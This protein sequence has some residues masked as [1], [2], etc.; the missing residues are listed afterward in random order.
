MDFIC[1]GLHWIACAT[2]AYKI[3][4]PNLVATMMA[5]TLVSIYAAG[6]GIGSLVGGQMV[7]K[8][9]F[10]LKKLF[11]VTSIIMLV[12]A[13]SLSVLYWLIG[14]KAEKKMIEEKKSVMTADRLIQKGDEDINEDMTFNDIVELRWQ[15]HQIEGVTSL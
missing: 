11:I 7:T 2:Y 1:G 4:P 12:A 3:C 5:L 8:L 9:G 6:R 10:S 15:V 14:K 13:A